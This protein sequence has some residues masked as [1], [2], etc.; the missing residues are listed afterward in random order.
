[1]ETS[2]DATKSNNEETSP[3]PPRL[4]VRLGE[5]W[6][7]QCP[8]FRCLAVRDKDSKWW[9]WVTDREMSGEMTPVQEL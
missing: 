6:I 9:D 8:G 1:M 4:S 5:R 3:R 7:V 2:I